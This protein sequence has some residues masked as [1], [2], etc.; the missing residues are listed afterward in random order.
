MLEMALRSASKPKDATRPAPT[1][2]VHVGWESL[3]G[4]LSELE[5]GPVLPT[6]Q[7]LSWMQGSDIVRVR[8]DPEGLVTLSH[9][10]RLK[11]LT[12]TCLERAV[13]DTPDRR[14]CTPTDRIFKGATRRAI[15]I[16]DRR[17]CHPYCDRPARHCQ[18][19]HIKPYTQGGPTTQGNGRLLCGFHNRW[20]YQ[21]EQRLDPSGR[22]PGGLGPRRE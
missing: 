22:S 4:A 5:G 3:H 9:A 7:I 18:V 10:V 1:V 2:H 12:I 15:E 6:S 19:D 20:Y 11:E 8:H 21:R 16:R 13:F 14:E 17:C